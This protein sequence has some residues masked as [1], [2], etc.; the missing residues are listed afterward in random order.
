MG[1]H[2]EGVGGRGGVG[3][4]VRRGFG[5]V[6]RGCLSAARPLPPSSL[7][8]AGPPRVSETSRKEAVGAMG[9][10][11]QPPSLLPVSLVSIG[12]SGMDIDRCAKLHLAGAKIAFPTLLA[13]DKAQIR[14]DQ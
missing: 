2:G 7:R 10:L 3:R 8:E 4:G 11:G 9:P 6:R 1:G 13:A 5:G 14:E 12:S